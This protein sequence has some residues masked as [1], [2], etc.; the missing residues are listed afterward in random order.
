M[1]TPKSV[2]SV[3]LDGG[4]SPVENEVCVRTPETIHDQVLS[5]T[6]EAIGQVADEHSVSP[7]LRGSDEPTLTNTTE[8]PTSTPGASL[9]AETSTNADVTPPSPVT[10][11]WANATQKTLK[12]LLDDVRTLDLNSSPT[13]A[14]SNQESAVSNN[15]CA[16]QPTP[17]QARYL[18][19]VTVPDGQVFPPGAEF[20]K[21]WKMVNE[22]ECDWPET[23]QLVFIAGE[24]LGVTQGVKVGPVKAGTSIDLWTGE[25]KAPELPGRYVSYWRLKNEGQLF[26][27]S[28]WIDI[29][30]AENLH[31]SDESLASSSV[32]MPSAAPSPN[33]SGTGRGPP[34]TIKSLPETEDTM[35]D[36]GSVSLMSLPASDDED[37][38]RTG[39][40]AG[41]T[42]Y[43]L[44]FDDASTSDGM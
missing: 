22:G 32:I 39:A 33:L 38:V 6:A 11:P 43:V 30:V 42:E 28:I 13:N 16:P 2:S 44:L 10:L 23:T 25:L 1:F 36:D 27:S 37:D 3:L 9:I 19:D 15:I 21:S 24:S 4:Q 35:S 34:S 40:I 7:L 5:P 29:T 20:V 12:H 14:Q 26:G 17:P 8:H 41:E 18:S 31:D